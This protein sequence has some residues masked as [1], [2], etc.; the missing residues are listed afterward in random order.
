METF[1]F[2][3]DI[4]TTPGAAAAVGRMQNRRGTARVSLC[5]SKACEVYRLLSSPTVLWLETEWQIR[6]EHT[7]Y[8]YALTVISLR[9]KT[10]QMLAR[11]S[12]KTA[13]AAEWLWGLKPCLD[14]SMGSTPS[15]ESVQTVQWTL[16]QETFLFPRSQGKVRLAKSLPCFLIDC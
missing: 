5:R 3:S 1:V 10:A 13:R 9:D 11:G 16:E 2:T 15:P 6:R 8:K 7:N 14:N 4:L 12:F